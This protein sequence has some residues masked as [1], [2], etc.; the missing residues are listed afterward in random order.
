MIM[1]RS[2]TRATHRCACV[3]RRHQ[4]CPSTQLTQLTRAALSACRLLTGG[5]PALQPRL[6]PRFLKRLLLRRSVFP[7]ELPLHPLNQLPQLLVA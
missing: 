4:G 1:G 2:T 6:V 7:Q 3:C 5:L